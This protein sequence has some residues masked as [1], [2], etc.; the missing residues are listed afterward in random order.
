MACSGLSFCPAY[1]FVAAD[2]ERDLQSLRDF[3]Q[4]QDALKHRFFQATSLLNDVRTILLSESVHEIALERI[5][6]QLDSFYQIGQSPGAIIVSRTCHDFFFHYLES[7]LFC[8]LIAQKIQSSADPNEISL[9]MDLLDQ[10]FKTFAF[11]DLSGILKMMRPRVKPFEHVLPTT[12][13][14]EVVEDCFNPQ[15]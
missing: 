1:N 9:E 5:I 6:E 14:P 12:F 10:R 13:I 3:P 4:R 2:Y 11:T 15:S 8:L 7:L